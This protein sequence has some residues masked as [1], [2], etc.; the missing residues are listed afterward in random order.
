MVPRVRGAVAGLVIG[1]VATA[2]IGFIILDQWTGL[3]A[4]RFSAKSAVYIAGNLDKIGNN[5]L[6]IN[7]FPDQRIKLRVTQETALFA[8]SGDSWIR[9]RWD[10]VVQGT[11]LCVHAYF[12]DDG[13]LTAGKI[14]Y[15]ATCTPMPKQ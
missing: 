4:Q 6:Y 7:Q 15:N 12:A 8:F 11:T 1:V 10:Q 14:F 2:L 13:V 3:T 5:E 9:S